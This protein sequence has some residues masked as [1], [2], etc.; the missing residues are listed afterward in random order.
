MRDSRAVRRSSEYGQ[1]DT[2]WSCV[3][4][5]ML[6]IVCRSPPTAY[7]DHR[8][9][10]SRPHP[11][12]LYY[13]ISQTGC[14]DPGSKSAIKSYYFWDPGWTRAGPG[15]DPGWTRAPKVLWRGRPALRISALS[16]KMVETYKRSRS[17]IC[18]ARACGGEHAGATPGVLFVT[19]L[20]RPH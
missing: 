2:V 7:P 1:P 6:D 16:I 15:S 20:F 8:V 19:Y 13:Y 9:P 11:A 18:L 12:P 3:G 4:T 5:T 10:P 14:Q 17:L